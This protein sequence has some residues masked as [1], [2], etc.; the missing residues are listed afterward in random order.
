MRCPPQPRWVETRH[1]RMFIYLMIVCGGGLAGCCSLLAIVQP[2][3][4]TF[5]ARPHATQ[6]NSMHA[7]AKRHTYRAG[8]RQSR[9]RHNCSGPGNSNS[10]GCSRTSSPAARDP[11]PH[12]TTAC[13][14]ASRGSCSAATPTGAPVGTQRTPTTISPLHHH[15]VTTASPPHLTL[16]FLYLLRF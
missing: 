11:R 4:T 14:R 9:R 8:R 6:L 10:C 1:T 7:R 12:R 2:T 13:P 5:G 16:I 15:C 3:L